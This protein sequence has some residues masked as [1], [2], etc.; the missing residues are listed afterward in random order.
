MTKE[1]SMSIANWC[2]VA[3][4]VLPVLT[5]GMAKASF[6]LK[7]SVN[8]SGW[9]HRAVAAQAN[10]FEA[11]PLFIA[12]IVLAQQAHADQARIDLLA[13]TFIGIRLAYVAAYLMNQAALRSLIWFTGLG[14][15]IAIL[16]MAG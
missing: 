13:M 4:C 6:G 14:V 11:L 16:A 1:M 5:V 10:G 15:S 9:Q 3:A 12:A 8:K 7:S 2:V